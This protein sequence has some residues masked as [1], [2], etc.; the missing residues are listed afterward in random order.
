MP[1]VSCD[2]VFYR[3]LIPLNSAFLRGAKMENRNGEEYKL[4]REEML[5]VKN[6]ITHY[7]GYVLAGSG[8]AL[9]FIAAIKK[10]GNFDYVIAYV[11]LLYSLIITLITIILSYKSVS[12]NRFAGYCQLL[13]VERHENPLPNETPQ[14]LFGWEYI[15]SKMRRERA[16]I[17]LRDSL[18]PQIKP[19]RRANTGDKSADFRAPRKRAGAKILF[20]AVV[21]GTR[22][23]SWEF[24][25][26]IISICALFS[27][28][29]FIA[30]LGFFF[31]FSSFEGLFDF[32]AARWKLEY[33]HLLAVI[34]VLFLQIM[35]WRRLKSELFNLMNGEATIERFY[36]KMSLPREDFL[37]EHGIRLKSSK[38]D[39]VVV[40]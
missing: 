32:T 30:G 2:N 37:K 9:A 34:P 14:Q 18:N 33:L 21:S 17:M 38:L 5:E 40:S 23:N 20:R 11:C 27:T 39:K 19:K 36:K 22:S 29:F 10:A 13:S 26:L 3:D 6:C 15:L 7:M 31:S 25:P 24:P 35:L 28:C 16:G 4:V 12:H 1:S 8:A